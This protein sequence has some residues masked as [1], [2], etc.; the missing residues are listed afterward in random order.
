[1]TADGERVDPRQN[2]DQRTRSARQRAVRQWRGTT[3]R[4]WGGG[5]KRRS[6][7]D[8]ISVKAFAVAPRWIVYFVTLFVVRIDIAMSRF[9][10][11]SRDI[12]AGLCGDDVVIFCVAMRVLVFCNMQTFINLVYLQKWAFFRHRWRDR[13]G[14]WWILHVD[15]QE[16]RHRLQWSAHRRRQ[17]DERVTC[18]TSAEHQDSVHIWGACVTFNYSVCVCVDLCRP[19]RFSCALCLDRTGTFVSS[20]VK[21][22]P[23][24]VKFID[25]FDKYLDPNFFQHR[26]C[27][28]FFIADISYKPYVLSLYCTISSNCRTDVFLTI[29]GTGE[30]F[31]TAQWFNSRFTGSPYSTHSW[32]SSSWSDWLAWS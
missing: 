27:I 12:V 23:S 5:K 6:E 29:N 16:I 11:Y 30:W 3:I 25:R 28:W 10:D 14:W 18:Q 8:R 17:F 4:E 2:S 22:Q 1:M 20:Q 26:V 32:W 31:K 7:I 13:E 15:P 21:W 19:S 24:T 9:W